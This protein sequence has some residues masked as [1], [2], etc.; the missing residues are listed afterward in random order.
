MEEIK[1]SIWTDGGHQC[2]QNT[3]L[4]PAAQSLSAPGSPSVKTPVGYLGV[5]TCSKSIRAIKLS[6]RC[7]FYGD[8]MGQ[9]QGLPAWEMPPAVRLSCPPLHG[10]HTLVGPPRE[11]AH[12][13]TFNF[14]SLSSL[15]STWLYYSHSAQGK[16]TKWQ[17]EAERRGKMEQLLHLQITSPKGKLGT[18]CKIHNS[19]L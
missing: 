10:H 12:G 13:G 7:S 18:N 19:D 3:A 17:R 5:F 9:G 6:Q 2:S 1:V 16:Q 8:D 15:I 4:W 11:P 14:F